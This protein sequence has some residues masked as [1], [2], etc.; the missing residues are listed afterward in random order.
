[1]DRITVNGS[2]SYNVIIEHGILD[3]VGSLMR[4]E[5]AGEKALIVTDSNVAALY[6]K[7]VNLSLRAA[8]YEVYSYTLE[9]GDQTKSLLSYIDILSVLADKSFS[10]TDVIV[11]LGG[12]MIGDLAGFAGSTYKRGMRIAQI[13]TSL[14]AAVDASVGGK[15][16]V[17]LPSGKN[18]VGTFCNPSIVICD[19]DVMHTL[20]DEDLHEGYAE[21]I[22]YGILSGEAILNSLRKAVADGDYADV[23]RRSVTIKRD[24]VQMDEKDKD[25]RQYLNL[26]HLVGHAIEASSDYEISHGQAVAEGLAIEARCAAMSGFI[27]MSSYLEITALLEEFN[28][29]ISKNYSWDELQ[30][31]LVRDKRLRDGCIDIILPYKVGQCYMR[32]LEA[33]RL[34]DYIQRGL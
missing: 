24:V 11:A 10:G 15:T 4:D 22:K 23:I 9:P 13:P 5:I 28:F 12:G 14:L 3:R 33:S 27:E 31:Y 2:T 7:T 19:P 32:H 16:A 8:G 20:S 21:I 34:H 17:N 26:G 18:Q 6:L 29:G 25:F 30:P 1:M